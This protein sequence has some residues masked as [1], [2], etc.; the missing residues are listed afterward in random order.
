MFG[1]QKYSM[2]ETDQANGIKVAWKS[3]SNIALVKYWGKRSVQIPLNPSISFT[4]N[5]ASTSTSIQ[6]VDKDSGDGGIALDL[7]DSQMQHLQKRF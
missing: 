2:A 3:A 5:N 7:K 6:L 1:A 4:L